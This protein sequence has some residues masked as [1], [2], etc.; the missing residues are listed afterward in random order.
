MGSSTS[1]PTILSRSQYYRLGWESREQTYREVLPR[2][3]FVLTGT[4]AG[5]NEIA[6]YYGVNPNNVV[7]VPLPAPEYVR[8]DYQ[9]SIIDIREKYGIRGDFLIYPAQFWPHKNHVNLLI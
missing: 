8:E 6:R 7:V 2:A 3:S 4:N 9:D 5:K 1:I